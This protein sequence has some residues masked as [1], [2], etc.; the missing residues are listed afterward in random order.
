MA[1]NEIR[2]QDHRHVGKSETDQYGDFQ[3]SGGYQ[4]LTPFHIWNS[5]VMRSRR[6]CRIKKTTPAPKFHGLMDQGQTQC[7]APPK[8]VLATGV[9]VMAGLGLATFDVKRTLVSLE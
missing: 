7:V 6:A 1:E 9:G 2:Q 5:T 4:A 8:N 3:A